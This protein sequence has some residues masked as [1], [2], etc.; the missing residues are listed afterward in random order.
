MRSLFFFFKLLLLVLNASAPITEV[1]TP[2][3]WFVLSDGKTLQELMLQHQIQ[4]QLKEVRREV[5]EEVVVVV[6]VEEH[7]KP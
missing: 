6:G 5:K 2:P 3:Y 7:R 1:L 4:C